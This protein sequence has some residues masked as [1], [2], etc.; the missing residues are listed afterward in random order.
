MKRKNAFEK[1]HQTLFVNAFEGESCWIDSDDLAWFTEDYVN[2]DTDENGE[3]DW[4]V[5]EERIVNGKQWNN[6]FINQSTGD[7]SGE[8]YVDEDCPKCS[9][10]LVTCDS[11]NW[12]KGYRICSNCDYEN[13]IKI[14]DNQRWK[15]Y[16]ENYIPPP[17]FKDVNQTFEQFTT[18]YF[19]EPTKIMTCRKCNNIVDVE[20]YFLQDGSAVITYK[21]CCHSGG[22]MTYTY[23]D[24]E[25]K[26]EWME[27]IG[28]LSNMLGNKHE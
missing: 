15:E 11:D 19:N 9:H 13:D 23:Y 12:T 18:K 5:E 28:D 16:H 17:K 24:K 3:S 7:D 2:E 26:K 22:M 25:K 10:F 14:A 27:L 21:P 8:Y 4:K 20:D 6:Q 1:T